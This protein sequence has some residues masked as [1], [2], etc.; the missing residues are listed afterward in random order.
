MLGA[1]AK[2]LL[3]LV[4]NCVRVREAGIDGTARGPRAF[5]EFRN[6]D[7]RRSSFGIEGLGSL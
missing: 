3:E 5:A 6:R 1:G 2:S 4:D 7:I